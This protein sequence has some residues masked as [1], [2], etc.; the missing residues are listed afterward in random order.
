MK[1]KLSFTKLS[2]YSECGLKYDLH[3]NQYLRP[4]QPK[5][6]LIFGNS[7]DEALNVLLETKD[8]QKAQDKFEELWNKQKFNNKELVLSIPGVVSFSKS[9]L[10]LDL[11]EINNVINTPEIDKSWISLLLKAELILKTYHDIVLPK[12]K[13][14]LAIQAPVK[15]ENLEGDTIEGKL[16]LIVQWEDG[17]NLLLDNKTTSVKYELDSAEKSEQLNLYYY[18]EK[19][20]YKLD[21]IGFITI[22][23]KIDWEYRKT[24]IKC[25][26]VYNTN[27]RTCINLIN[28]KRCNSEV[29]IEKIPSININF[30]INNVDEK[31]QTST[32]DNFDKV[33]EGISNNIFEANTKNCFGKFGKCV[34]YNYCHKDSIEGLEYLV[35][36]EK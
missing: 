25:K 33:N 19:D 26:H 21:A 8:L 27:H 5:S 7:I 22:G 29:S 35:K 3:Y 6:A 9:D 13:Q 32:I 15:I 4:T 10:D 18:L 23:K 36:V 14:V 11:L 24:C 20:N 2:N 16:D 30:I 12:I 28:N 17:R 1:N 34:Y 31:V